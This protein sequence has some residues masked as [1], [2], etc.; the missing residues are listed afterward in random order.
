MPYTRVKICGIT[1]IEDALACAAE[2]VDA[3]G[4]VFVEASKRAVDVDQARAI[5]RSLPPFIQRVGLFMDAEPARI[6]AVLDAV[7]LDCL[8]F[9]GKESA[10]D[11]QR[12]CRPWIKALAMQQDEVPF[13]AFDGADALLLDSHAPGQLG[14]SGETFDW[15]AVPRLARPWILAGGLNPDNVAGAIQRLRP[16]AVDVSSGVETAPGIKNGNLINQF[17][18]AIRNG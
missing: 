1:R 3:I 4:L 13:E 14:G 9:H 11:C 8:Q 17:M 15:G 12:Y 6:E 18:K 2:G 10:A 7:P 16:S 5:C